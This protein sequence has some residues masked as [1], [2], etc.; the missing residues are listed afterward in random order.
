MDFTRFFSR[1]FRN[2]GSQNLKIYTDTVS[3]PK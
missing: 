2:S 1:D 3:L